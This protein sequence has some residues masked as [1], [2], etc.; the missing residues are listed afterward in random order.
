MLEGRRGPI[1][2][3]QS[4]RM[5]SLLGGGFAGEGGMPPNMVDY[6]STRKTWVVLGLLFTGRVGSTDDGIGSTT[7]V[8]FSRGRM[9]ST[10][11]DGGT[12]S[13]TLTLFRGGVA[14]T[15]DVTR[16]TTLGSLFR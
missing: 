10:D 2:A 12:R 9:G 13:T 11:V 1:S 5:A 3:P 7:W 4:K 15:D 6:V 8:L 16:E 14:L